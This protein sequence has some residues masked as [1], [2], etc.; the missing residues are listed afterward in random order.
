MCSIT[1]HGSLFFF[2]T[3]VYV[4]LFLFLCV[5]QNAVERAPSFLG[6]WAGIYCVNIFVVAWVFVVGFGFGGW[7]SMLNFVNQVNTFGLFTKCYQCPPKTHKAWVVEYCSL[8]ITKLLILSK[9]YLLGISIHMQVCK[10]IFICN[11]F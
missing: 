6:G 4:I 2:L 1:F 9:Q 10:E 11:L 8:I 5:W 7:A 3:I